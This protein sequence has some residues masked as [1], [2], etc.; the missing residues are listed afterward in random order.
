MEE[1]PKS[2]LDEEVFENKTVKQIFK[3]IYDSVES[4]D[5]L[6]KHTIESLM[7]IVSN[8]SNNDEGFDA[9]SLM[10]FI[11]P[12]LKD[13]IDVSVKN[14]ETLVKMM[15]IVYQFLTSTNSGAKDTD[16]NEFGLT[17]EEREKLLSDATKE[18]Q[19][20]QKEVDKNDKKIKKISEK[21]DENIENWTGTAKS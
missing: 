9:E 20:I 5:E 15:K 14:K 17:D 2:I 7:S 1:L 12:V 3:D 8:S 16:E 18:V 21:N 11:A 6:I 19:I 10:G 4:D 13:Y